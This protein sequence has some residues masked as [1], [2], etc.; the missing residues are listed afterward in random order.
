EPN[1]IRQPVHAKWPSRRKATLGVSSF[2]RTGTLDVPY[3]YTETA[4]RSFGVPSITA[5]HGIVI[6]LAFSRFFK[7]GV[8]QSI[9]PTAVH[10]MH[11][12]EVRPRKDHRGVDLIQSTDRSVLLRLNF[13]VEN[14][15]PLS[16][17]LHPNARAVICTRH[18]L[19]FGSLLHR[20]FVR[21]HGNVSAGEDDLYVGK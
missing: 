9:K 1:A 21:N 11:V 6:S 18:V 3:I 10:S 8:N 20:R 5:R 7:Q 17:L 12:Y 14:A 4:E 15:K 16:A 13:G 19:A 2:A